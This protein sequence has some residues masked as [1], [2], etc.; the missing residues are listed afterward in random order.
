MM[1]SY[2]V[3]GV[4]KDS[5]LEEIEDVYESKLRQIDKEVV[6]EKNAESFK[7]LLKEAHD[8][9]IRLNTS[10][11][12]T[13]VMSKEEFNKMLEEE[14]SEDDNY[15]DEYGYDEKTYYEERENRKKRDKRSSRNKKDRRKR[16]RTL[17]DREEE[18]NY[19]DYDDIDLPWYISIPLKIVALPVIIIF[20]IIIFIF[21]MLNAVLWAVTKIL[22]LASAAVAAIHG[23]QVYTGM[24]IRYEVFAGC[25]GVFLLSIILPI[26]F[27]TLPKPL[28]IMN[29]KLKAF[30]F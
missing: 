29:N 3:L 21:E 11:E 24:N 6:N 16:E 1:D 18:R 23:Y 4:S 5:S 2:E 8:D 22:I 30:V 9:L 26:I 27:K 15:Y 12:N 20:S 28:K 25:A 7:K 14:Q 17:R 13:V 19:S 10:N